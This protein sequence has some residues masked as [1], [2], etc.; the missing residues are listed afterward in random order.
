MFNRDRILTSINVSINYPIGIMYKVDLWLD[1]SADVAV[2][3]RRAAEAVRQARI[4]NTR[5]RVMGLDLQALEQQVE[6]R[7]GREEMEAQR[8]KAFDL[9]RVNQDQVLMQQ[10]HEEEERK[11]EA[12]RDLIHYRATRQRAEDTRDADLTFDRQG[13]RG[14]SIPVPDTELG[15]ASMQAFQGEGI[16]EKEKRRAQMEQTERDLREQREL[17]VKQQKENTHRELLKGRELVQLDLRAVQLDAVEEECKRAARVALSNY[18][19][20]QA[21]ERA[22]KERNERMR[23]EGEDMAEVWHMVTSDILTE[24]PEAALREVGGAIGSVGR[25]RVLTDRWKGMAPEQLNAIQ[26]QREEQCLER[27]RLR[28]I[29]KQRE[30][31]WDLQRMTLA[32]DAEE[33]ERKATERQ[34]EK[35]TEMDRHNEQLARELRQHQ[36]YLSKELYTNKPTAKFFDQFSRSSR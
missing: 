32:R 16:G 23:K 6:E 15:P 26:M 14:W 24:R 11:S 27:E 36:Q 33:E 12:N 21:A 25:P 4:F 8:E 35:R 13:A 7:R 17:S 10:L 22:E 2:E 3:R 34:K 29:D 5:Q 9:L 20:A 30:A 18:H 19:L 31:A 28:K 1:N